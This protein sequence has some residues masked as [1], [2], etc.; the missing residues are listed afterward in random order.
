MPLLDARCLL[1]LWA[2][3]CTHTHA[4]VYGGHRCRW[5]VPASQLP[6]RL[7][8]RTVRHCLKVKKYNKKAQGY[9]QSL[10]DFSYNSQGDY[11]LSSKC[12]VVLTKCSSKERSV[13]SIQRGSTATHC[14]TNLP[15]YRQGNSPRRVSDQAPGNTQHRPHQGTQHRPLQSHT[16]RHLTR[17]WAWTT[18]L[19]EQWLQCPRPPIQ[20]AATQRAME[21]SPGSAR[22]RQGSGVTKAKQE[23]SDVQDRGHPDLRGHQVDSGAHHAASEL[24]PGAGGLRGGHSNTV[25]TDR[26]TDGQR[27]DGGL[28]HRSET[29]SL[30]LE[31]E[32]DCGGL[33][34]AGP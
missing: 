6:Q 29:L 25:N 7:R 30:H 3:T 4:H 19:Y 14:S 34:M 18:L 20:K 2:Q 26:W 21:F 33:H 1:R 15:I 32:G 16:G 12:D 31:E 22:S 10:T 24:G 27:T 28:K 5:H 9:K 23:S 8:K 11:K 17:C 13:R